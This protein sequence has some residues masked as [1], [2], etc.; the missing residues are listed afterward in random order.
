MLLFQRLKEKTCQV[1][2][3]V[4]FLAWN[5]RALELLGA[6]LQLLDRQQRANSLFRISGYLPPLKGSAN[7]LAYSIGC[8]ERKRARH[9]LRELLIKIFAV[10]QS[11]K[12]LLKGKKAVKS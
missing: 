5:S 9:M 7:E 2:G 8:S 10:S 4:R 11:D 1:I 6:L 12:H 3:K